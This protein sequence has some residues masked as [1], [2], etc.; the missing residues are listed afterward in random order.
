L[1]YGRKLK[2]LACSGYIDDAFEVITQKEFPGWAWQLE[3]DATTL[4]ENWNGKDSQNHIMFGDISAWMYQYLGGIQPLEEAPG[5]KRFILKPLFPS[6]LNNVTASY[7][8][9]Y[10]L[11]KSSWERVND[12]IKCTFKIPENSSADIVLPNQNKVNVSGDF[13]III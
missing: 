13:E 11:I 8:S 1:H 6:K 3:H 7:N 9:P 5:F 4:W 10:G 2:I 12:K